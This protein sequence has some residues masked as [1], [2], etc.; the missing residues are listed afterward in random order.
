MGYL[1]RDLGENQEAEKYFLRMAGAYPKDYVPYVALGDL[2]TALRTFDKAQDS[3]ETAYKLAPT[4]TQ[5][6][7]GG[8][9]AA[10]DAHQIDLAGEWVARAT[11]TVENDPR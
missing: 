4:N 9:N 10:I 1:S 6:I 11:G 7:V 8:S 3:Y 2:Y 5:I